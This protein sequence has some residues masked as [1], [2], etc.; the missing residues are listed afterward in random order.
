MANQTSDITTYY[1]AP[2]TVFKKI[3]PV[4]YKVNEFEANKTFSFT[5]AS[6]ESKNIA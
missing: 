2:P 6:A 5:S 4:N 1:G 3:D